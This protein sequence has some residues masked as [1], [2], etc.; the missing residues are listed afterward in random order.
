M[1]C[2]MLKA[3]F[4]AIFAVCQLQ[5]VLGRSVPGTHFSGRDFA[6]HD[7]SQKIKGRSMSHHEEII[8]PKVMIIS[9]VYFQQRTILT[10]SLRLNKTSGFN[11]SNCIRTS[12]SPDSVHFF[13]K[14]TAPKT[15]RYAK[16]QQG[17]RKSMLLPPSQHS[18][19]LLFSI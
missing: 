5:W 12:P 17:R 4:L 13:P 10:S 18:T 2:K 19:S 6:D 3:V 8:R 9:M 15:I 11:L 7:P 1:T 16:L 14:H